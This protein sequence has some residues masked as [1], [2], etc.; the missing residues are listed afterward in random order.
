MIQLI[1]LCPMLAIAPD[2]R[3]AYFVELFARAVCRFAGRM[4]LANANKGKN[5]PDTWF[6]NQFASDPQCYVGNLR[7]ATGLNIL[8]VRTFL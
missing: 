2:S 4:P 1:P 6:E 5:T 8:S 3:P 7:I